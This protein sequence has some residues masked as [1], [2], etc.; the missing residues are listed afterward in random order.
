MAKARPLPPLEE[1]EQLLDYDSETGAL[2]W[3]KQFPRTDCNKEAGTTYKTGNTH[4]RRVMVEGRS[5]YAHRLIYMLAT[6]AD[7]GELHIDHIDGNGLNNKWSNIR[8]ATQAQNAHNA[9]KPKSNSS[10]YKGVS[11]LKRG[12]NERWLAQIIAHG[13][14]IYLGTFPTPEQAHDAYCKAAAE[15][16]GDFARAA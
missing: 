1:L 7:P 13:K 10:G 11:R 14:Q 5:Y 2:T 6:G 8:V 4:Y 16:H 9:Q 15:L 3:R 12:R